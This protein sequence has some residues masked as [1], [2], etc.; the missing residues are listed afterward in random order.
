MAKMLSVSIPLNLK[1]K[2]EIGKKSENIIQLISQESRLFDLLS[3]S[4]ILI[5]QILSI[6]PNFCENLAEICQF[7][8]NLINYR[9]N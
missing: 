6:S 9:K 2:K 3:T 7:W 4:T 8:R 1:I 5:E